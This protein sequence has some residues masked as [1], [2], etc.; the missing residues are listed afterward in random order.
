MAVTGFGFPDKS[1]DVKDIV[2]SDYHI[3]SDNGQLLNGRITINTLSVD[4]SADKRNW[5]RNGEW[6][7]AILKM[8]STNLVNGLFRYFAN[9]SKITA[10][11]VAISP[12]QLDLIISI[13]DI[14]QNISLPYQITDGVLKA[15]GSLELKDYSIDEAL[16]VFATV[17]TYAWHRGKT[18]TD[19]KF[20]F[21]VPVVQ[22]DCQ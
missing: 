9:N 16:N 20:D 5:D 17:C 7:D 10:K 13:N 12:K 8:R 6:S 11:V 4:A 21:S 22:S 1:Y 14:S 19:I 15:T 3:E 2:F 18:W